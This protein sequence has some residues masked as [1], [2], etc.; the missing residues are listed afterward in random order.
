MPLPHLG[1]TAV[2]ARAGPVESL[3]RCARVRIAYCQNIESGDRTAPKRSLSP[4]GVKSRLQANLLYLFFP[5]I[6]LSP[7]SPFLCVFAGK[8][9]SRA[10][11][12]RRTER[13]YKARAS[14][15][16][17]GSLGYRGTS[18]PARSTAVR[19]SASC[20]GLSPGSR[21][22]HPP[23]ALKQPRTPDACS[24]QPRHRARFSEQ[25]AKQVPQSL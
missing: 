20:P 24:L 17:R 8:P 19:K 11:I 4:S 13:L 12:E 18:G 5:P 6:P 22:P 25:K 7:L 16:S 15:L 1:E 3:V 23:R 14:V 9:R 21:I 2:R 10:L